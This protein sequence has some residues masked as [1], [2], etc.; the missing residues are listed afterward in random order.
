[1]IV[2]GYD[3]ITIM[4]DI[5]SACVNVSRPSSMHDCDRG[6]KIVSQSFYDSGQLQFMGTTLGAGGIKISSAGWLA[7]IN[8]IKLN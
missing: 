8:V 1:M 7:I 5:G 4:H 3:L 2:D 6:E